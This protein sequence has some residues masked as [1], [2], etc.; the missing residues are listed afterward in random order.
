MQF[1]K[2]ALLRRL[3]HQKL[4][5]F[6]PQTRIALQD[7]L[8]VVSRGAT[9][10]QLDQSGLNRQELAERLL[11]SFAEVGIHRRMPT[12]LVDHRHNLGFGALLVRQSKKGIAQELL[13]C[14]QPFLQGVGHRRRWRS[15]RPSLEAMRQVF[16]RSFK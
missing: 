16:L 3:L 6:L 11:N 7:V 5:Q 14:R 9:H 2:Q 15:E 1:R 4:S 13:G 12:Q 8:L 10:I